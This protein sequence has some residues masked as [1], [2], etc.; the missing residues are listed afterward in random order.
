MPCLDEAETLGECIRKARVWLDLEGISGEILVADNGSTDGSQ[1]IAKDLGAKVVEV[2]QR[3][4]GAALFA[5]VSAAQGRFVIMG[6]ADDSYDFSDLTPFLQQLR[7]GADLVMGN[8][9][10]G[11][12][13]AGAMPLK[14]RYLGNPVLSFIGRLFFSS[15][16]RD[17]HCGLR[18]FPKESFLRMG[19]RTTGMEFASEMVIKA[20]LLGMKVTEVPTTLSRDGRSRPPHLRP[21][22]D[23]LRHLK[24]MLAMSPKW[25]LMVP[26]LLTMLVSLAVFFPLLFG[27]LSLSSVV[28]GANTRHVSAVFLVVGYVQFVVGLGVRI[29]GVREGL[30]PPSSMTLKFLKAP[31]FEAAV[32]LGL[33][34]LAWGIFGLISAI[35]TW[36]E[37]GFS[38]LPLDLLSTAIT[39]YGTIATLGGVTF[40]AG[41]LF[42]FFSIPIRSDLGSF[43]ENLS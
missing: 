10:R 2:K 26:G 25:A 14:S 31:I 37:Y 5:G 29:F 15:K 41:L 3:G 18:A 27:D 24:F 38:E 34:S 12:I 7:A 40:S 22:R 33:T 30:L 6:D 9:F 39:G 28:L 36:G 16:V 35:A 20:T 13:E 43:P 19:L 1:K 8:R 17:F 42:G 4:Y 21:W 32:F 11:G 23:G